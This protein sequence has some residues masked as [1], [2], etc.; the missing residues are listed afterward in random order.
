MGNRR[1]SILKRI[2]KILDSVTPID[3]DCGEL[4]RVR[5]VR[6]ETVTHVAFAR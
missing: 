5:C 4:C 1:L 3:S 6:A 2:Y